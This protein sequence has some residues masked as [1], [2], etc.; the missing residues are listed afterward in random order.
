V[1][2]TVSICLLVVVLTA[3]GGGTGDVAS[4]G[5]APEPVRADTSAAPAEPA[6]VQEPEP[7]LQE[8]WQA[9]FAVQSRGRTAPRETRASVVRTEGG[10][11]PAVAR[12]N[13]EPV[14]TV[15]AAE[16]E[17]ASPVATEAPPPRRA[18]AAPP[19]SRQPERPARAASTRAQTHTVV[20]GETFFG[21]ARR[22][23]VPPAALRAANPGVDENQIRTGQTLRIPPA[24]ASTAPTAPASAQRTHLVGT[25]DTLYGI[26]RR[27]GVSPQAIREANRME[28]DN[29]R[30]G[31]TLV[32]PGGG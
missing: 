7:S 24:G 11:V 15:D 13:P 4:A 3:C 23:N 25:G 31:Q 21:I 27:Y 1:N 5:P 18:A 8:R 2:R 6:A 12:R 10:T 29:V 20:A 14:D 30:L 9:P 19:P 26:A 22:Y 17:L 28:S 32:I 16:T